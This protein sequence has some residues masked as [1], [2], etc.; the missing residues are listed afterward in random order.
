VCVCVCLAPLRHLS[1]ILF[2]V[3]HGL[4]KVYPGGKVAVQELTFHIPRDQVTVLLLLLLLLLL[5]CYC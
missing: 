2:Q 1:C 5:L 4:R 3:C